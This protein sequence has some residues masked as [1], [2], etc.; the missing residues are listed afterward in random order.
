MKI[1]L[2]ILSLLLAVTAFSQISVSK[3]NTG[4]LKKNKLEDFNQF[5]SSTTVFVL[6]SCI[7][8]DKYERIL[9][10]VWSVTDY[11]VV[12]DFQFDMSNY[13]DKNYSFV[14]FKSFSST[15]TSSSGFTTSHF[16]ASLNFSN[17]DLEYFRNKVSRIKKPK[18]KKALK[19]INKILDDSL[20]TIADINL[21]PS[22]SSS[23]S[24]FSGMCGQFHNYNLG[25]LK[26]YFQKINN[27]ILNNENFWMYKDGYS[28]E[29]SLLKNKKLY[30]PQYLGIKEKVNIRNIT[31]RKNDKEYLDK[32]M[33]NYDY[34]FEVVSIE[35]LNS[36]ISQGH[37]IYYL[38]YVKSNKEKF[39]Q[40]INSVTGDIIYRSYSPDFAS[41]KNLKQK[42]I[43]ALN[44]K[45]SK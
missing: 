42:H 15:M 39:L 12:T 40:V 2:T 19:K 8:K 35:T 30:I 28:E 18:S 25:F 3:K 6:S 41:S 16:S 20:S 27:L 26:N 22:Y 11:I 43:R 34:D 36:L 31:I 9:K 23:L 10:D 1:K 45:A 32:L 4:R 21:Y 38:T 44:N 29:L 13:L 5:K 33:S 14:T 24:S 7:N 17:F 37:E